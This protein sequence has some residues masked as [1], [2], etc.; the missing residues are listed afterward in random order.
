MDISNKTS[1]ILGNLI[2]TSNLN[3]QQLNKRAVNINDRSCD[4]KAHLLYTD[5]CYIACSSV[6]CNK[7]D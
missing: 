6:F 2:R 4:N 1:V 7:V 3:M 5:Q